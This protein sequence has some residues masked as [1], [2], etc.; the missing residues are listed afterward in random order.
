MR[1]E[2]Q[3]FVGRR[4]SAAAV[5][6]I[7][8]AVAGCGTPSP[9]LFVVNRDG[10]V[11]GAKLE[12]LVSDQTARCNGGSAKPLSSAQIIEARDLR[13]DLLALQRGDDTIPKA[14]PSQFFEFAVQTEE[15]T[16]R[17]PDTQQRPALLPRLS[18]FVRRVAIDTCGLER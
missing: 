1:L 2:L 18:R 3:R 14:P 8:L 6:L 13:R 11:P 15:G 9:D 16:L 5:A 12:L 17:Y 4:R 10:T 7:V